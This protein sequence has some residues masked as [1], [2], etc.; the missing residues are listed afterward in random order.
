MFANIEGTSVNMLTFGFYF[1]SI[2][3]KRTNFRLFGG[4]LIVFKHFSRIF[5][6]HQNL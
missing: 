4:D 5:R 3:E 6:A 2:L 1:S